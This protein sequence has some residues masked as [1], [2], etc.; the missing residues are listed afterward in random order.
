MAR[1]QPRNKTAP[2]E[3]KEAATPVAPSTVPAEPET[4][5][6][7]PDTHTVGQFGMVAVKS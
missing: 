6:T 5:P 7:L 4:P 1:N 3:E 2:T